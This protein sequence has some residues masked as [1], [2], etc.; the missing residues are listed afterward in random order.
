YND[1][2]KMRNVPYLKPRLLFGNFSDYILFRKSA[3]IVTSEICDQFPGEPYVGVFYGTAPA[4]VV[5]DPKLV[6]LVLAQDFYYFN[7]R[8]NTDYAYNEAVTTSIFFN[9]GDHWK[10]LRQNLTPL[11][12]SVKLKNMFPRIKEC[13]EEMDTFLE[14]EI[15]ISENIN[16]KSLLARYSMECIINCVFGLRANTLKR[17]KGVNPFVILGEQIFDTSTMTGLKIISRSIWPSLFYALGFKLFDKNIELF[18]NKLFAEARKNRKKERILKKDFLDLND[19]RIE[20]IKVNEDLLVA[21]CTSFFGAGFE[22]TSSTLNYLLYE[23][24]KNKRAQDRVQ[25]EVDAYFNRYDV[26]KYECLNEMPY[27]E[28][29]ID[30]TLRLYPTLGNLTREV[31]HSYTLPTGLRLQKGDRVHIPVHHI[32]RHPDYFQDPMLYQPERFFGDEKMKIKPYT[33]M[34]FGEGPRVCIGARFSKMVMY[35]GLLTIFRKYRIELADTPLSLK[36]RPVTIVTQTST[37]VHVKFI[38]R[39]L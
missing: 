20:R 12:T 11:F 16:S 30:E 15:K 39:D 5:K 31:M 13:A 35:A 24:A 18:F 27:L 10:V 26:I 7:G 14:K 32:H 6:K 33:F 37:I 34:P 1:Y 9:G 3:P 17:D 23:L 28:A 25:E 29:C 22:T 19:K 38:P 2:W 4:L 36:M 21:Q 8:E